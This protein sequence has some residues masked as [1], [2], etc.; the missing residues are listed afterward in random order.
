M[1]HFTNVVKRQ[2]IH[3][4][5]TVSSDL[6]VELMKRDFPDIYNLS[7]M[8][9]SV[10]AGADFIE[11]FWG[12][13]LSKHWGI[14]VGSRPFAGGDEGY[15]NAVSVREVYERVWVYHDPH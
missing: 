11:I 1:V 6:L 4:D 9:P 10:S 3:L 12:S 5:Q 14:R 15:R 8:E 7:A 2:P 13:A